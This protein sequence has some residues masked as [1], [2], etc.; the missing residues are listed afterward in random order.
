MKYYLKLGV[1]KFLINFNYK[2]ED[3]KEKN[4][5]FLEYVK[6][7]PYINKI[8]YNIGP[9]NEHRCESSNITSLK[10]LVNENVDLEEDYIIPADSDEFQ[11]FPDNL[12]N[13]IQLMKNN[14]YSYLHGCTK[15]R[16]SEN[17]DV[18]MVEKDKDIF[19]QFPN[20]NNYLFVQPKISIIKAK[21]FKYIGVGHHYIS[22]DSVSNE[23]EKEELSISKNLTKTN[24]FKWNL[25]GKLRLENWY[26]LWNDENYKSWKDVKKL[27]K[28]LV[29]FNQNLLEYK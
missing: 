19:K 23:K 14:Q 8:I 3:D 7:T 25:Q 18:I 20:Y 9:N 29:V 5:D 2:F 13:T 28:M 22:L 6:K 1:Y 12:E 24:H 15:E 26:K 4:D 27:E 17:G 11:E 21:Y 10:Q 16:I